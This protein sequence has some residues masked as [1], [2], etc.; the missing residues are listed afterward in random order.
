MSSRFVT[1][2]FFI[3][4]LASFTNVLGQSKIAYHSTAF[5]EESDNT[6]IYLDHPF[7]GYIHEQI[8]FGLDPQLIPNSKYNKL[9]NSD[10]RRRYIQASGVTVFM[11]I[12]Y[13]PLAGGGAYIEI[14]AYDNN[15]SP[16]ISKPY[17]KKFL[18][19]E[20]N[21]AYC[22][23]WIKEIIFDLNKLS[24]NQDS[25]KYCALISTHCTT[26]KKTSLLLE[27]KL[28]VSSAK[29]TFFFDY[30]LTLNE[31]NI[32]DQ[33]MNG[34]SAR[35]EGQKTVIKIYLE[36]ALEPK[37]LEFTNKPVNHMV[38]TIIQYLNEN[39]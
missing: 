24:S 22:N 25:R 32:E 27:K 13:K 31:T 21:N 3:I 29:D 1:L 28:R 34:L 33:L 36:D 16:L 2:F 20:N 37:K 5:N 38:A 7:I 39:P 17:S 8:K 18:P 12:K 9:S 11:D 30:Q 35:K 6:F 14:M 23:S 4:G 15:K 26:C 19:V 10:Y